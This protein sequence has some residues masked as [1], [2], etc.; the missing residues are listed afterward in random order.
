[1]ATFNG[2]EPPS[3]AAASVQLHRQQRHLPDG[4]TFVQVDRSR[5][6]YDVYEFDSKGERGGSNC[7]GWDAA[8][9]ASNFNISSLPTSAPVQSLRRSSSCAESL[10][11][12]RRQQQQ[13]QQLKDTVSDLWNSFRYSLNL[14]TGLRLSKS[15]PVCCLGAFYD[16]NQPDQTKQLASDMGSR[17]F[18]C[19]RKNFEPIV[20]SPQ[21]SNMAKSGSGAREVIGR[22]QFSTDA[23]WGCMYRCAQMLLGNALQMLHLGRGWRVQQE[24]RQRQ[25]PAGQ[26]LVGQLLNLFNESTG[27]L[28]LRRLLQCA[29]GA[30]PG[31]FIG[32]A[33][34]AEAVRQAVQEASYEPMLATLSVLVA[35]QSCINRDQLAEMLRPNAFRD[36]RAVLLLLPLWLGGAR[37]ANP[38]Y[39]AALQVLLGDEACVGMLGGRPRHSVY[40]FGY[41]GDRLLYLDPHV[42]EPAS[43]G[44]GLHYRARPRLVRLPELD[45]S[46][47]LGF[48]LRSWPEADSFL[49]RVDVCA[50]SPQDRAAAASASGSYSAAATALPLFSIGTDASQR[51]HESY[52]ELE[53]SLL[54][55]HQISFHSDGY[56]TLSTDEYVFL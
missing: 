2:F 14:S 42:C 8:P 21:Q 44:P 38:M 24:Q 47:A 13:Q 53:E 56:A 1:M 40:I 50:A 18:A 3:E 45:P 26:Q 49:R 35:R 34:A 23:G 25:Q 39:L 4:G 43:A 11:Q 48:L 19:Y 36:N 6:G 27:Q 51:E 32:P 5:N 22:R 7:G 9:S 55:V 54:R 29:S 30:P 20:L 15:Q 46:C 10:Q 17:F 28:S 12:P 37:Q 41:Q 52:T 33:T 16:T 31:R